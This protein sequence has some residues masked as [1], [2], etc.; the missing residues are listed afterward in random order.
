MA[1][2]D[3]ALAPTDVCLKWECNKARLVK[4]GWLWRCS[5][6]GGS[7]GTDAKEALPRYLTTEEQK[8]MQ[9]A[10]RRSVRI[11]AKGR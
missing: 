8:I 9:R 1:C 3:Q 2:E 10:L 11:I 5:R 4:F 6:C 7:Y